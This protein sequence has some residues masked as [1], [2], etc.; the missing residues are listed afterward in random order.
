MKYMSA[1]IV[2]ACL[3]EDP[4]APAGAAEPQRFRQLLT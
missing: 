3:H 1:R 4:R 2:M